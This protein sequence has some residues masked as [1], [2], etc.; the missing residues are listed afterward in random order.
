MSSNLTDAEMAKLLSVM[1]SFTHSIEGCIAHQKSIAENK[2]RQKTENTLK[3]IEQLLSEQLKELSQ[4]HQTLESTQ[5]T[6]Q[7]RNHRLAAT[8]KELKKTQAQLIQT[9]KMSSLGQLVAG[10]AHEINNPISFIHSNLPHLT[11]YIGDLTQ[12]IQLY[13]TLYPDSHI[14][15]DKFIEN[16]ELDYLL[17]DLPKILNSMGT[18]SER[19]KEIVLSLNNFSRLGETDFKAV[20]LHQGLDSTLLLLSNRL[21]A[22]SHRTEIQLIKQYN[23]IPPI[24]C[25]P[26]QLNQVFMNLLV[27][28]IDAIDQQAKQQP[29]PVK[30]QSITLRTSQ[31]NDDSVQIEI[32]DTGPGIAKETQ[33]QLF[34]PF[35]TTKPVGKG[36]GL[37]LSISYKIVTDT[38]QGQLHCLSE[39][40]QG[41]TFRVV[42][43]IRQQGDVSIDMES[44]LSTH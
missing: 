41:T 24:T 39:P 29:R 35:F 34:D 2:Q 21:K 12:L 4:K 13:R 25:L 44:V 38:H 5:K 15:L 28:A 23:N 10:I 32:I 3:A 11:T 16:I 26:N 33:K 19:I 42:L 6:L 8:L 40:G 9:E 31:I 17:D 1:D 22:T 43:P 18:G 36:T 7:L 14:E 30:G 20:D 27:N 37:G